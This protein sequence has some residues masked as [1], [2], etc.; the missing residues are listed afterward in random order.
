MATAFDRLEEQLLGAIEERVL[1]PAMI[2]YLVQRCEDELKR[3][4][5]EMARRRS[6]SN[7]NALRSQR[8]ELLSRAMLL[9]QAIETGGEL[10]SLTNRLSE[11]ENQIAGLDRAIAEF[12]PLNLKITTELLRERVTS[13]VMRLREVV[14]ASD[15]AVAKNTLRKHIG[16]LVLTPAVLNGRRLFQVSGSVDLEPDPNQD[17]C[18]ILLVA[19]DGIE[20]PPAFS[21]PNAVTAIWLK[22][23]SLTAFLWSKNAL[24]VQPKCNH[25]L[26]S[27]LLNTLAVAVGM[28]C[29]ETKIN[30]FLA[31]SN[32]VTSS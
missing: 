6:E 15:P 25:R 17:K 21:G 13:G 3:R 9:T 30:L 31:R 27:E 19:R 4:L 20:P 18:R 16:R 5:A 28:H 10:R 8:Q 24:E 26:V 14:A 12:R 11:I 2:D 7:L 32:R 22:L 23:L 29:P 1:R